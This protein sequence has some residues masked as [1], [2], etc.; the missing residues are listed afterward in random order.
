[1]NPDH[2]SGK[3]MAFKD[4]RKWAAAWSKLPPL[5]QAYNLANLALGARA[6]ETARQTWECVRPRERSVIIKNS[7]TGGDLGLSMSILVIKALEIARDARKTGDELIFSGCGRAAYNDKALLP[8]TG[9][10]LR[11]TYRTVAGD[12]GIDDLLIHFLMGHKPEGISGRYVAKLVLASGPGLRG[13]QRKISRRS[14][15]LLG[16]RSIETV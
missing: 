9:T 16:N 11:R 13:A 2:T 1:M 4:F 5:R 12:I 6:V 8:P 14:V 3:G 7:K 15:S 10:M